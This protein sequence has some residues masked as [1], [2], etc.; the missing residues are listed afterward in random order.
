MFCPSCGEKLTDPDQAFCSKCGSEI[1]APLEPPQKTSQSPPVSTYIPI[2]QQISTKTSQPPP[3]STSVQVYQPKSV[4]KEKGGPGPYSIKCLIFALI[5]IGLSI[6]GLVI[7]SSSMISSIMPMMGIA[8]G[9]L[10]RLI[11]A[12]VL[13]IIGLIFGIISRVNSS[14]AGELEPVNTVEKIGSIL[15][16]FGIII[17]AIAIALALIIAP[18]LFFVSDSFGP[19]DT[20]F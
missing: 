5:S 1:G 11:L 4:K 3:E 14:K 7:G 12:I 2:S 8:F 16:I 9:F 20:F 6:S 18:I 10:P 19:W 17:N 15:A 13:N